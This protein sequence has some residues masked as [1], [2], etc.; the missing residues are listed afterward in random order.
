MGTSERIVVLRAIENQLSIVGMIPIEEGRSSTQLVPAGVT[1]TCVSCFSLVGRKEPYTT[2][3]VGY[4][5]GLVRFFSQMGEPL[6]TETLHTGPV[7]R[8]RSQPAE[9][10]EDLA[11]LYGDAVVV[12]EG[13][14]LGQLLRACLSRIEQGGTLADFEAPNGS[15]LHMKKWG[16]GEQEACHDIVCYGQSVPSAYDRL[17]KKQSGARAVTDYQTCGFRPMVTGYVTF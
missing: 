10:C 6:V 17:M 13:L 12:I 2:V 9:G 11:V 8:I 16:L 7:A 3:V 15:V 5:N 1:I 14:G 4:S